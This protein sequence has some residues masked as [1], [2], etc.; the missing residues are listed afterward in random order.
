M[1]PYPP[2]LPLLLRQQRH[3]EARHNSDKCSA[4]LAGTSG[5]K[6]TVKVTGECEF[7][8]ESSSGL[9]QRALVVRGSRRPPACPQT[10]PGPKQPLPWFLLKASRDCLVTAG[11]NP[12]QTHQRCVSSKPARRD[13]S[14]SSAFYHIKKREERY[15]YF[16]FC[17]PPPVKDSQRD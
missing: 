3:A 10:I 17:Q 13:G 9:G 1:T 6:R 4:E 2:L 5:R 16:F 8:R 11:A 12:V 14:H 7:T 15:S